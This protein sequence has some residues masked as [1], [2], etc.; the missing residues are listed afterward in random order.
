MKR[1][2]VLLNFRGRALG[3]VG[4]GTPW[5]GK[6]KGGVLTTP[7]VLADGGKFNMVNVEAI[8]IDH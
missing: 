7:T 3:W 2:P 1:A 5:V 6:R 8:D 4:L